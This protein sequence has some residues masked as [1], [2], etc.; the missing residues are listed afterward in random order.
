LRES[1]GAA[2]ADIG[3]RSNNALVGH[4]ANIVIPADSAGPVLR[5]GD[6]VEVANDAIGV[7]ANRVTQERG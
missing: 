4:G 6:L 7:L 3:Y 2:Q 1:P 5:A